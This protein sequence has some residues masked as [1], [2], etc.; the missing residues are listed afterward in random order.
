MEVISRATISIKRTRMGTICDSL[1]VF[2]LQVQQADTLVISALGYQTKEWAVPF[3]F[4]PEFPPF[5]SIKMED[6]SYLLDDVDIYALG[7]WDEFKDD[8]LNAEVKEKNP[9][10]TDIKKQLKPYNTRKPNPV[11]AQ[12]RPKNEKLGVVQAIF[13]PTDFL[14]GKLSKSEKNKRK[15][16][17]RIKE[18]GKNNKI[19]KKYNAQ[20]VA[21]ATGLEGD[22]LLDFMGFCGKKIHVTENSTDYDVMKQIL[23]LYKEYTTKEE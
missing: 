10:N 2:H 17:K 1:G 5:F 13:A 11:P 23:D 7:S 6:I 22:E 19:S 18:E 15:L 14:F 12:Y 21:D 9:I 16:S 20:I 4:N 8:F 3:I